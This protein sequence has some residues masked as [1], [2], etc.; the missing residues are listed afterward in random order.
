MA[1]ERN[2]LCGEAATGHSSHPA[3]DRNVPVL[4]R[5]R[6]PDPEVTLQLEDISRG[7]V[8][9]IPARFI[10]LLEL[11]T[12]VYCADQAVTRGGPG[13]QNVGGD[14]RRTLRFSIPVR[15]LD[16]WRSSQVQAL[17]AST[18]GFLS[19]RLNMVGSL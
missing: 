12:Y 2:I 8:E 18:L 4:L 15:D 19:E 1:N 7:F 13:V 9:Q 6:G 11:A 17:L 14:W 5:L 16:F 3:H 10:D